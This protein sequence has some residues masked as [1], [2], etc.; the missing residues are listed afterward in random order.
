MTRKKLVAACRKWNCPVITAAEANRNTI[1]E[2]AS[3]RRLSPSIMLTSDLGT[4]TS[5]MMVVA[6]MAS[7]GDIMPPKRKPN[8]SVNCGM[9]ALDTNAITQDVMMTIGKAKL[10]IT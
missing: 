3:F 2:E 8:A 4:F 9:I 5:R 7:G 1:R 6:E 10:V